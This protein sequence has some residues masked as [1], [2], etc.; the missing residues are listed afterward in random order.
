MDNIYNG[1][2]NA[3]LSSDSQF[4]HT[5]YNNQFD[6]CTCIVLVFILFT[7]HYRVRHLNTVQRLRERVR[8]NN[9]NR[10]DRICTLC[11]SSDIEDE[12]HFILKCPI[13]NDLRVNYIKNYYYR[14]PSVFKLVQLL[15]VNNVKIINN[16]GKYLYLA[17]NRRCQLLT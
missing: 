14:M 5:S 4:Q 17:S 1:E 15:S 13:Y 16:L 10:R 11:N 12:F 7:C 6:T 3:D 8:Y 9:T 2:R